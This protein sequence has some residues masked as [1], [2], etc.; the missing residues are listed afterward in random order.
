MPPKQRL[1]CAGTPCAA[2]TNGIACILRTQCG[3]RVPW[4]TTKLTDASLNLTMKNNTPDQPASSVG[5]RVQRLVR[6]HFIVS[7]RGYEKPF[8]GYVSRFGFLWWFW[9][10][11]IHTQRPDAMNPSVIRLIWL[12]CAVGVDIWGTESRSYWPDA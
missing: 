1:A 3:V 10:P 6:P 11:R 8:D 12:C 9:L 4:L 7:P 5:V 2:T